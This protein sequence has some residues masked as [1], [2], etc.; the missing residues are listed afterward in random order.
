MQ[1]DGEM[2]AFTDDDLDRLK[3]E[4]KSTDQ[5]EGNTYIDNVELEALLS[6]LEAAEKCIGA[7]SECLCEPTV[8]G[9]VSCNYCEWRKSK[10]ER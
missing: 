5:Y 10:G 6:R 3:K 8:L 7:P 2:T 9:S 1:G 4:I